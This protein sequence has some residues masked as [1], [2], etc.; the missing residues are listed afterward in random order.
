[1]N[2]LPLR[3]G[4][5]VKY[6]PLHTPR[7]DIIKYLI[8]VNFGAYSL[9]KVATGPRQMDYERIYTVNQNSSVSGL[10]FQHFANISLT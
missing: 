8:L 2:L 9:Y 1:M 3:S 10:L 4:T 7:Q 5:L 6:L